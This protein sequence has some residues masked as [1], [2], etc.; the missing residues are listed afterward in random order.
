MSIDQAPRP[1]EATSL[2]LTSRSAWLPT[3]F[4]A[5]S[6]VTTAPAP[7]DVPLGVTPN[8]NVMARRRPS[9][10]TPSRERSNM[11]SSLHWMTAGEFPA[12]QGASAL[13]ASVFGCSLAVRYVEILP[14][15]RLKYIEVF[16]VVKALHKDQG[17]TF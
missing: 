12:A 10:R 14:T 8:V 1:G 16:K 3:P 17:E 9:A 15:G 5:E 7:A 11:F 4:E 2:T 13:W 6:M